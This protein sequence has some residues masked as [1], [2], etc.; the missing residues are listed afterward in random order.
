MTQHQ[1]ARG[2]V[3]VVGLSKTGTSTLKVMLETLGYRVCGPRK[4]L[5][6]AVRAGDMREVDALLEAYDAFEDWPWPLV[7]RHAHARY[8]D[9]IRFVLTTRISFERWFKSLVSHG[10]GSSPFKG[11]G[12]SYGYYRPDGNED[13]FRSIYET[14]NR[15]VREYFAA[16]PD[17]LVEMCLEAGDG[18]EKLS[19]FLGRPVPAGAVPHAN[20]TG[21]KPRRLNVALNGI[22]SAVY[23][24]LH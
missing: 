14:H 6:P 7:Y 13:A 5:L 20:R 17:R 9:Q 12:A 4:K 18:W 23:A 21:E 15:E 10:R 2:K 24:R 11:M 1:E 22:I 3:M 8:G 19:E 16:Y